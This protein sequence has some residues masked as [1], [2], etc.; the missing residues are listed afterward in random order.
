MGC[1]TGAFALHAA[2]YYRKI[3]AVDIARAMLGRARRK[4]RK[5]GLT[6][7]EFRRGG[8]LT[9]EHADD[10]VDAV[11]SVLAL[12]HLPDFW[13]RGLPPTCMLQPAAASI[14]G[15]RLPVRRSPVRGRHH[16]VYRDDDLDTGQPRRRRARARG[17]A[18]ILDHKGLLERAGFH[19]DD[20][21]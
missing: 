8:F 13:N 16:A 18:P 1:G 5:A 20:A 11:V 2:P 14:T 15:R 6:N 17:T 4:A 9:Y 7:I 10:P 12:H 19:I 21:T 3:Y